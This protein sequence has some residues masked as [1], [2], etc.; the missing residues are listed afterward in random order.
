MELDDL[1]DR[2][3]FLGDNY[4]ISV[5]PTNGLIAKEIAFTLLSITTLSPFM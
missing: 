2:V 3:L 1:G 5:S 4:S